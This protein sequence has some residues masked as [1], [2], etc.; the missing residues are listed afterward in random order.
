MK[1]SKLFP[2]YSI[3]MK[4]YFSEHGIKY[5]LVGLN[6]YTH[7]MFWVYIKTPEVIHI[8]KEWNQK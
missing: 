8:M 2:C 5:E 3:N 7:N 1:K 4:N 6:P